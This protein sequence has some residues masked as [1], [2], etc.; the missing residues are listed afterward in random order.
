MGCVSST[1]TYRTRRQ[2]RKSLS[3]F[4]VRVGAGLE[5]G[6]EDDPDNEGDE[7]DDHSV[8]DGD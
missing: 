1:L 5:A 4:F 7:V 8:E 3:P 2:A 6:F